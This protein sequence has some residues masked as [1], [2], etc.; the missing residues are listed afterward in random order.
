[1]LSGEKAIPGKHCKAI[2]GHTGG[3]VTCKEMRPLDWH[4]YRPELANATE[5]PATAEQGA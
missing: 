1:M 3:V 2:E 5:A 4:K